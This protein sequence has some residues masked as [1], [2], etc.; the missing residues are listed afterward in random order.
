MI[1]LHTHTNE[2]DGSCTPLELVDRALAIGLEALAISDHDT[3]AGYDQAREP[4]R[5]YGLDL[6]CGIELSVRMSRDKRRTVHVLAYF[7]HSPPSAEFRG[8]VGE[9]LASRRERNLRLVAKLQSMG[10]PIELS[11]VER[12]GRTLTGRPHFARVLIQKGYAADYDD[13]FRRYFG[14]SGPA[15]VERHGPEISEAAAQVSAA[16]GLAVLA[17]PIR[18]GVRD[19]A[20]EEALIQDLKDAGLAGLEVY[21]S[22]HSPDDV[23]RYAEIA[24]KYGLAV[25]GGSDFHG[26]A[27]PDIALGTG[28]NGNL[29]IPRSVLY[30]LRG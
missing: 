10:V 11:E 24:K 4:A 16:G 25:T 18:L 9:L 21:H 22:D 6:V 20:A 28:R 12:F 14:E 1:D 7:L 2:S 13:A 15:F 30:V 19:A 3:F 27:K 23:R 17:H 26:D 8:W 5:A 29:D